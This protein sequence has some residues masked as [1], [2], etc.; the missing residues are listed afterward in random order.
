[1]S[2]ATLDSPPPRLAARRLLTFL[3]GLGIF[4]GVPLAVWGADLRAFTANPARTAYLLV[5]TIL[6]AY[7]AYRIPEIGKRRPA[8]EKVVGRQRWAVVLLQA[9]SVALI[10]VGPLCDRRG[11]AV[12]SSE[13]VRLAGVALY[14]AGFLLMHWAEAALGKQFS[15]EV[16]IQH[17]HELVTG[18]PYRLVRHPRYLGIELFSVGLALVFRSAIA[19]LLAAIVAAVLAWRIYDEEIL[20]AQEFG[21][22]WR[23]YAGRSWRLIPWLY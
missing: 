1:M 8:P 5:V 10:V 12:F 16:A 7:A 19:L 3:A 13:G 22:R 17:G 11:L 4:V 14:A 21:E 2:T 18:G 6:N 9:L 23:A 20:M 15:L